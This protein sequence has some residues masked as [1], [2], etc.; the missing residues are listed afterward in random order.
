MKKNSSIFKMVLGMPPFFP[1]AVCMAFELAT[2]GAMSGL[3]YQLLPKKKGFIYVSLISSMV[4]G[5]L[6]WGAAMLVCT[7]IKGGSF[8]TATF[9]AGAEAS[10]IVLQIMLI[11]VVV[12][13]LPPLNPGHQV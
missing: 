1:T 3:F 10:G 13:L 8:G 9:I 12:M 6:V 4:I 11:P 5:R 2:Y 7:G